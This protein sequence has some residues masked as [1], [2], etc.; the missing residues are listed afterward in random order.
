MFFKIKFKFNLDIIDYCKFGIYFLKKKVM[1][2]I[3]K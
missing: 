1:F 3:G 2:N